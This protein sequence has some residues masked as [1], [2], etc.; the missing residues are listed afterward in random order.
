LSK[1]E[2]IFQE[3]KGLPPRRKKE[4]MINLKES[5]E[6]VNVIGTPIITKMR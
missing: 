6:A 1:Y 2:I 5:H 3:P 4:H